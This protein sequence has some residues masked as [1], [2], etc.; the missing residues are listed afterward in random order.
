MADTKPK[1]RVYSDLNAVEPAPETSSPSR[2]VRLLLN[3]L[4]GGTYD[5]LPFEKRRRTMLLNATILTGVLLVP[6]GAN[7]LWR[8]YPMVALCDGCAVVVLLLSA[9]ILRTTGKFRLAAAIDIV[10]MG[11]L[12]L[13]LLAYGGVNST[14]YLWSF[15][16]PLIAVLLL[17]S[18]YGTIATYIFF[19]VILF[20]FATGLFPS[21]DD[22]IPDF[23][24][25]YIGAFLAVY[26][27]VCFFDY[28]NVELERRLGEEGRSVGNA[29]REVEKAK[30]EV[31]QSEAAVRTLVERSSEPILIL[32]D[33]VIQVANSPAAALGGYSVEEIIG[34]PFV[35]HIHP[36]FVK[37]VYA[38][39]MLRIKGVKIAER[40][41][42]ALLHRDGHRI[43]V[44]IAGGGIVMKGQPADLVF[45]RRLDGGKES[46]DKD[47]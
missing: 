36:D 15:S 26:F 2:P 42:S 32:Q 30:Q 39:Y 41:K 4:S 34:T 38:N 22:Y 12:L 10:V 46:S 37:D 35:N 7:A 3:F 20:L 6:Y 45:V 16:F 43:D 44:E 28:I 1:T 31:G 21:A 23:R 29:Q 8:G 11:C 18:R 24:L 19:G 33:K 14:G 40:Y 17:G 47:A 27:L 13:Y 9:V 5:T 25:R